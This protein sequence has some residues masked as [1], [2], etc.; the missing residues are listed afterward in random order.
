MGPLGS[1]FFLRSF[2]FVR[3]A[4]AE[5]P[6]WGHCFFRS[7]PVFFLGLYLLNTAGF[8]QP[9][10]THPQWNKHTH[11]VTLNFVAVFVGHNIV[12]QIFDTTMSLKA[13]SLTQSFATNQK[14]TIFFGHQ[15]GAL[16]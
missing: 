14:N 9:L 16:C 11:V 6:A 1:H 8:S 15:L 10:F 5:F 12:T 2:F 3:V 13:L 7:K 4:R